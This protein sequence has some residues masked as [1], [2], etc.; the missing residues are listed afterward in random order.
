MNFYPITETETEG[1]LDM[2]FVRK[3]VK[4]P[5]TAVDPE[6]AVEFVTGVGDFASDD[7]GNP[8][9]TY[10][11]KPT[12]IVSGNWQDYP[13]VKVPIEYDGHSDYVD[14]NGRY[15]IKVYISAAGEEPPVGDYYADF[16]IF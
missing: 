3:M 10:T 5:I 4:I 11:T 15:H 14:D 2:S 1:E 7:D 13:I 9:T 12:C 6:S 16:I 8:S